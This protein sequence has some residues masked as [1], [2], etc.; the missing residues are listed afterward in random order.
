MLTSHPINTLNN[1]ISGYYSE[2]L[3]ICDTIIHYHQNSDNKSQGKTALGLIKEYKD[4]VDV[5]MGS[6]IFE[7]YFNKLLKP[8]IDAYVVDYPMAAKY[9]A[10]GVNE[11]VQIQQYQPGG[12]YHAWHCERGTPK[13]PN[14]FR[15]L[16]FMTYLNTVTDAGETEWLHQNLR[17]KPEKG[18]TIVWPVDWPF[19]HRG[20]PSMSEQKFIATGWL[21]FRNE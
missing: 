8:A 18:L 19:T 1:F 5:T 3:E 4:S 7:Q 13:E 20:I 6:K 16:V 15:Y 10:F 14:V 11:I 17:V 21:S 12:A 9:A 2:E